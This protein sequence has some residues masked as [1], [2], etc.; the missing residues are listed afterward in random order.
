MSCVRF[1]WSRHHPH[2]THDLRSGSQDHHPSTNWEQK[3]ICCNLTSDA[4]D[5]GRVYPKHVEVKKLQLITLLHQVGSS[6]YFIYLFNFSLYIIIIIIIIIIFWKRDSTAC[7]IM[8]LRTER[9]EN[10]LPARTRL[11]LLAEHVPTIPGIHLDGRRLIFR[12]W[13]RLVIIPPLSPLRP[14]NGCFDYG[15]GCL[16]QVCQSD[17]GTDRTKA[18]L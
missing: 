3:T 16:R 9:S 15:P 13:I 18:D 10:R 7:S 6:L 2:R 14:F 4:P 5:D 1:G 8:R 17:G 12:V 11:F